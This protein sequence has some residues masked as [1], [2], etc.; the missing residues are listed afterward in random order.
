MKKTAI[1]LALAIACTA[2]GG[3]GTSAL[4]QQPPQQAPERASTDQLSKLVRAQTE[5]INELSDKVAKLEER[6]K[7]LEDKESH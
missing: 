5:A 7:A 4:G 2:L 6:V 3:L 1:L